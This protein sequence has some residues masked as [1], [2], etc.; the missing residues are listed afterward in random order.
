MC[1]R[2]G[3][4]T[5]KEQEFALKTLKYKTSEI[6]ACTN[7]KERIKLYRNFLTKDKYGKIKSKTKISR[8]QRVLRIPKTRV[9][10]FGGYKYWN[11]SDILNGAKKTF[12]EY[13]VSIVLS[14]QVEVIGDRFYMK[15]TATIIDN[16]SDESIQVSAY[17]RE[18]S[19][20]KANLRLKFQ[21]LRAV[22]VGNTHYVVF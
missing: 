8:I 19:Q 14:D 6:N 18:P 15:A 1:K 17:A 5:K 10:K 20:V 13:Q 21:G 4:L 7:S 3:R 2:F 9:N 12:E 11:C 22:I 16:E